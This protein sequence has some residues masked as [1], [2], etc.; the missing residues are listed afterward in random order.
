MIDA[1]CSPGTN[2][3]VAFQNLPDDF[4]IQVISKYYR[5]IHRNLRGMPVRIVGG[6]RLPTWNCLDSLHSHIFETGMPHCLAE[7]FSSQL[8]F[9]S[10]MTR[11]GILWLPDDKYLS[12]VVMNFYHPSHIYESMMNAGMMNYKCGSACTE[13]SRFSSIQ[14]FDRALLK[15][16]SV[17]HGSD[18]GF[19]TLHAS[20]MAVVVLAL[21]A[22]LKRRAGLNTW[23]MVVDL[24][25]AVNSAFVEHC[26]F[27]RRIAQNLNFRAVLLFTLWAHTASHLSNAYKGA[28]FSALSSPL[29]P[30]QPGNLRELVEYKGTLVSL[31]KAWS[32]DRLESILHGSIDDAIS[33]IQ[34]DPRFSKLLQDFGAKLIFC[35]VRIEDAILSQV[36]EHHSLECDSFLATESEYILFETTPI[37]RAYKI[38][39]DLTDASI[40]KMVRAGTELSIFRNIGPTLVQGN[41]VAPSVTRVCE[42]IKESGIWRMWQEVYDRRFAI[43]HYKIIRDHLKSECNTCDHH[44]GPFRS[45]Q[46]NIAAM[47]FETENY[48]LIQAQLKTETPPSSFKELRRLFVYFRNCLAIACLSFA[49][50]IAPGFFNRMLKSA[51][52]RCRRKALP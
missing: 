41:F 29:V 9:T 51:K 26:E 23:L 7:E 49:V 14:I 28:L 12:T 10:D 22:I 4:D 20:A 31:A 35:G 15:Q 17:W 44:S 6:S 27:P 38:F 3:C 2:K 30:Q 19:Y 33:K 37:L 13:F 8:N 25:L 34:N 48:N 32:N 47:L 50:E 46:I 1:T 11:T 39:L 16:G 40:E 21:L 18:V 42:G 24:L 52:A 5:G 36:S 45:M 43:A